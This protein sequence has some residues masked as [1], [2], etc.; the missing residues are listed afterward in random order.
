M[1]E[2]RRLGE[3]VGADRH[4]PRPSRAAPSLRRCR[5]KAC[6]ADSDAIADCPQRAHQQRERC[7]HQVSVHHMAAEVGIGNSLRWHGHRRRTMPPLQR[8]ADNPG[9]RS[10]H[11]H[12][13]PRHLCFSEAA[14]LRR[15]AQR[16]TTDAHRAS[17]HAPERTSH[18]A[19][20]HPLR[21]A[22]GRLITSASPTRLHRC[23]PSGAALPLR[24]GSDFAHSRSA[25]WLCWLW[26]WAP[27]A[28]LS[29]GVNDLRRHRGARRRWR[30]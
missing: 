20:I 12:R 28:S 14:G 21:A 17:E 18:D 29:A 15:R 6:A 7:D 27:L 25:A 16:S 5:P 9:E 22:P 3:G 2:A 1:A 23:S 10:R 30:R 24:R 26:R 13:S 8:I 19:R 4:R 11:G